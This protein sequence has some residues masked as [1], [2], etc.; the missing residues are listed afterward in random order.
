MSMAK[1][2]Y[3]SL[4]DSDNEDEKEDGNSNACRISLLPTNKKA[5]TATV[6]I[7][8][9]VEIKES[10]EGWLWQ[11]L[12]YVRDGNDFEDVILKL[13][14][15]NHQW[16]ETHKQ[17]FVEMIQL[18]LAV[19]PKIAPIICDVERPAFQ[20]VI[21]SQQIESA[22][23]WLKIKPC[24]LYFAVRY[25]NS[26]VF[27]LT[28]DYLD[29]RVAQLEK[30][31]C[32]QLVDLPSYVA[33]SG[34]AVDALLQQ[35]VQYVDS[36]GRNFFWYTTD[37]SIWKHLI[38]RFAGK[39]CDSRNN[40]GQNLLWRS[41]NYLFDNDIVVELLQQFPNLL[42]Q[43]DDYG[44]TFAFRL[45]CS[46]HGCQEQ[47]A[48]TDV[49][50][51]FYS[52]HRAELNRV[53]Q[54]GETLLSLSRRLNKEQFIEYF[55]RLHSESGGKSNTKK[56]YKQPNT[57]IVSNENALWDSTCFGYE[58][59]RTLYEAQSA[60]IYNT[61]NNNQNNNNNHN[62]NNTTNK[63]E[64]TNTGAGL[65]SFN[66]LD[67][68]V[69]FNQRFIQRLL[70][71]CCT[72]YPHV[73]VTNQ[74]HHLY[75][76]HTGFNLSM[77]ELPLQ[78]WANPLRKEFVFTMRFVLSRS[79]HQPVLANT[80]YNNHPL[81]KQ[82][83]PVI[84]PGNLAGYS[85]GHNFFWN[86]WSTDSVEDPWIVLFSGWL[87]SSTGQLILN[88][89]RDFHFFVRKQGYDFRLCQIENEVFLTSSAMDDVQVVRVYS[90]G[91]GLAP[92]DEAWSDATLFHD[93]L[94]LALACNKV[95]GNHS[96]S[97]E[98]QTAVR[99][100][101]HN[102]IF[103]NIAKISPQGLVSPSDKNLTL[104]HHC[105]RAKDYSVCIEVADFFR[106]GYLTLFRVLKTE[107]SIRHYPIAERE[108]NNAQ[109]EWDSEFVANRNQKRW[110]NE[111]IRAVPCGEINQNPRIIFS[112]T[113][114]FVA[115]P[116]TAQQPHSFSQQHEGEYDQ[117]GV[118]HIK[119]CNHKPVK[120]D[121]AQQF[122]DGV[123]SF[124][125]HLF[126]E[127]YI[128][129][130][131]SKRLE[132]IVT[133]LHRNSEKHAGHGYIYLSFFIRIQKHWNE[134]KQD[135]EYKSWISRAFLPVSLPPA[136][137]KS[138]VAHADK[139]EQRYR[140]S[141]LFT[142][143]IVIDENRVILSSGEG[144]YYNSLLSFSLPSVLEMT[145]LPISEFRHSTYEYRLLL[146]DESNRQSRWVNLHEDKFKHLPTF[147]W[148]QFL[149]EKLLA[150]QS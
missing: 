98:R 89:Q 30:T 75:R 136:T 35:F 64:D 84:V 33:Q 143:G 63:Q 134:A 58:A 116:F 57:D 8:S 45:V 66:Y 20:Q 93:R 23:H 92:A 62:N 129:H 147:P 19:N 122:V 65:H 22:Y 16:S 7:F 131:G 103:Q 96:A 82:Q 46:S 52:S 38:K 115:M 95:A 133:K 144:D 70:E 32:G 12:D 150:A 138:A 141:L 6:G 113:S 101:F 118:G 53:N 111:R 86:L 105:R 83:Q 74:L 14:P 27:S 94:P 42:Y 48:I 120:D 68:S 26:I 71:F 149:R 112:Y 49:L 125:H 78:N 3:R 13:Y 36:A 130:F 123:H 79:Y 25:R 148:T 43:V 67:Q 119:L 18:L 72:Y 97:P 108:E 110:S 109:E 139:E 124:M 135:F 140:F 24:T 60:A 34:R 28:M 77:C 99:A 128:V 114:P 104:I 69:Q 145:S 102:N 56:N 106:K 146:W 5:T 55:Q 61:N 59:E 51:P 15:S 17:R 31:N 50:E 142:T 11:V 44:D 39:I 132:D 1:S 73:S 117:L 29:E 80:A 4:E 137:N 107:L 40:V 127:R 76:D 37:R 88:T 2:L 91:F 87:C 90:K 54:R 21:I 41:W 10:D 126:G 100:L 9:R 47:Q 85:Q 81:G 121:N